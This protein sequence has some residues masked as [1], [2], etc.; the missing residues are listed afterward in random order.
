MDVVVACDHRVRNFPLECG[1]AL[2]G[3][4]PFD[5]R[6]VLRDVAFM[7]Y[8]NNIEF[9]PLPGNPRCLLCEDLRLRSARCDVCQVALGVGQNNDRE[10][11]V[12]GLVGN[13]ALTKMHKDYNNEQPG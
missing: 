13:N 8:E 9:F 11:L 5:R 6:V 1:H 4:F 3:M 10:E 7:Q 12:A 2:D